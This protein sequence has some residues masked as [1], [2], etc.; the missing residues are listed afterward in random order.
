MQFKFKPEKE[1][2]RKRRQTRGG[3]E[4]WQKTGHGEERSSVSGGLFLIVH[5]SRGEEKLSV[6][7]FLGHSLWS[8]SAG[9]MEVVENGEDNNDDFNYQ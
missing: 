4:G 3:E 7:S 6:N 1:K 9:W 8:L 5:P 2:L